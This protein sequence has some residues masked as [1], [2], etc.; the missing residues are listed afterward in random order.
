MFALGNVPDMRRIDKKSRLSLG[1]HGLKK[2]GK[3]EVH[4]ATFLL[5]LKGHDYL[6][7]TQDV[8]HT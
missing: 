8:H 1:T 2:G 7:T 4:S 5:L 6:H 3:R